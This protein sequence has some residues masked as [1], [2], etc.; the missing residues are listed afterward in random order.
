MRA[1]LLLFICLTTQGFAKTEEPSVYLTW[2]N[3]PTT[4][5]TVMWITQKSDT[6]DAVHYQMKASSSGAKWEVAKGSHW[7]LPNSKPFLVHKVELKGLKADSIYS[8]HFGN[9]SKKL[10]F[11]TMPKNLDKPIRFVA[12]GDAFHNSFKRYKAMCKQAAREN[13]RFAIIGGDIAYAAPKKG[14]QEN[15]DKWK[16]FFSC[17]SKEMRDRD[18]C[19]IPLLVTIGNHEVT[20]SF[21]RGAKDAPFYYMFFEKATYDIS[22]GSYAHFTFLDSNHTQKIKGKQTDWL[23]KTLKKNQNHKHR[24]AIYHVGAY[25]SSGKFEFPA[26]KLVRKHWVPLFEKYKIHACIESHDHAYK[27]THPLVDG[28]KKNGGVVYFGDGCW[29]VAPRKPQSRPYLAHSAQK[30]QILVV[31]LANDMRK[32][33]SVDPK[34]HMLDYYEQK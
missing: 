11:R 4:T 28:K 10:A 17:W 20:G 14:G 32:F 7:K 26:S 13:P 8:F 1:L 30:Q 21:N 19:L 2:K 29:G 18:G 31:E 25:P 23:K 33:W 34:G 15:W 12:G 3:D 27:R 22:F 9:K 24:F 16:Q 5:M 6:N